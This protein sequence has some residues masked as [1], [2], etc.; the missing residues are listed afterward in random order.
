MKK[1][2]VSILW[3]ALAMSLVTSP[4]PAAEP[5]GELVTNAISGAVRFT[6]TDPGI[7]ARLD[8]P[9]DE[10]VTAISVSAYTDPPAVLTASTFRYTDQRLAAARTR[11]ACCASP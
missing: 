1:T 6:N 11:T 9:G 5:G 7:L 2:L 8:A 10:G 3:P 4:V